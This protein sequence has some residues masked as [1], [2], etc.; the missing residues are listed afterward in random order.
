MCEVV[1]VVSAVEAATKA[2]KAAVA[3]VDGDEAGGA[4]AAA[5]KN[6]LAAM[7]HDMNTLLSDNPTDTRLTYVLCQLRHAKAWN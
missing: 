3:V 1:G 6:Q 7:H 2:I 5:H 4:K